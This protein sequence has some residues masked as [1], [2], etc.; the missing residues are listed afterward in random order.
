MV[1][2]TSS[3]LICC[4]ESSHTDTTKFK[5]IRKCGLSVGSRRRRGKIL[6]TLNRLPQALTSQCCWGFDKNEYACIGAQFM[7]VYEVMSYVWAIIALLIK[8]PNHVSGTGALCGPWASQQPHKARLPFLYSWENQHSE[9]VSDLPKAT[10]LERAEAGF[11][12]KLVWLESDL[13]TKLWYWWNTQNT[14]V[15]TT[16][17]ELPWASL[18]ET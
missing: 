17:N 13:L 1:C 3:A 14:Q 6:W 15:W 2:F 7:L 11:K 12:P 8:H 18:H 5:K 9:R 4:P 16:G 10:Q